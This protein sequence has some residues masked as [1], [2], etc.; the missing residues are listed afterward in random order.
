M[1]EQL[2]TLLAKYFALEEA[3]EQLRAAHEALKQELARGVK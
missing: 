2:K 3:Y 1:K